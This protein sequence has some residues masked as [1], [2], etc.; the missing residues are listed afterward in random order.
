M[1]PDAAKDPDAAGDPEA[2]GDPDAARNPDE[3]SGSQVARSGL[4]L[5]APVAMVLFLAL[6][7]RVFPSPT[8]GQQSA[9]VAPDSLGIL[10]P[11][12]SFEGWIPRPADGARLLARLEP[13][14]PDPARQAFDTV[15]LAERFGL[16]TQAPRGQDR[17]PQPWRLSLV[18]EAGPGGALEE[19]A[20]DGSSALRG[21][22]SSALAAEAVAPLVASLANVTVSGLERL[23]L[24]RVEEG[25]DVE[26]LA[27][28]FGAT[29]APL[30][31][32]ERADLIFWGPGPTGPIV[33]GDLGSVAP[34]PLVRE[35]RRRSEA[36][37]WEDAR[38]STGPG[39][40][41]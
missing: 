33:V 25:A 12:T 27:A 19:E 2:A 39:A 14:H 8:P 10:V 22:E 4:W 23:D 15:V 35:V 5:F 9:P 32:G 29:S 16:E 11:V 37:A 31:V 36:V 13:L 17:A 20:E 3:P 34:L 38:R 41:K 1:T 18:A 7:E 30:E 6:R 40:G 21:T 28:L 24:G 26:L